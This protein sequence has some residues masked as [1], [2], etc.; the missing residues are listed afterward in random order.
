MK[1]RHEFKHY[2]NYFDYIII[3]NRLKQVME[4][5]SYADEN[6]EYKVRS[7]YFDNYNDKVLKEKLNG[8]N[9]RDKYRIRL[10]NDDASFIRLEKKS[11]INGLCKKISS[12]ISEDEVR[13]IL[14]DKIDFLNTSN[15]ALFKELFEKMSTDFLRPKTIV[16][17]TRESYV[18]NTGNV[19]I[20]FDKSIRSAL[21]ST[22][23][24]S[25]ALPTI[26]T[27]GSNFIVL[28]V[29]YDEFL[30][31]LI[32]D[33][34]QIKERKNSSISKYALCRMYN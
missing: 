24:L 16:D 33:M 7:L 11:K 8:V 18:Y 17:Y 22:N 15:N 19:R 32:A 9:H 10:Y 29:K 23:V 21:N 4:N 31:E 30:P 25:S 34:L 1:F 3:S 2:I 14:D 13:L 26:E 27:L 28:E 5:D 12:R 6:G 20:T